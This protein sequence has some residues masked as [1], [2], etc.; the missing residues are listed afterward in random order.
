MARYQD[1]L[2]LADTHF[3]RVLDE[4]PGAMEC[5]LGCTLCCQG[6]FE[7]SAADLVV[8]MEGLR[9]LDPQVLDHLVRKSRE[10]IERFDHPVLSSLD[11]A[12]R[13]EFFDGPAAGESCPALSAEGACTIYAHRPLLCRTFGLPV[14]EGK[15]YR[16]EECELNFTSSS[17]ADK[18]R[19]A[20]DL[21]WE[22]AVDPQELRTIPQ[23]IVLIASILEREAVE[24]ETGPSIAKGSAAEDR[25]E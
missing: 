7:I 3:R 20:W 24:E 21:E 8:L 22:D 15:E 6:L 9:Q 1:V 2:A 4:Q 25:I 17:R 5:R 18:E 23:A 12:E 14:R 13:R 19:A 16:G 11:E 10:S